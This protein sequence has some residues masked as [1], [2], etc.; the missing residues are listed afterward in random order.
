MTRRINNL[1]ELEMLLQQYLADERPL[2][3]DEMRRI[4]EVVFRVRPALK[5]IADS[6]NITSAPSVQQNYWMVIK[7]FAG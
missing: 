7:E 1:P 5:A 3:L 6:V 2:N 4:Y